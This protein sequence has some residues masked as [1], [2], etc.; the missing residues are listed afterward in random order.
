MKGL[1]AGSG[2]LMTDQTSILATSVVKHK[3]VRVPPYLTPGDTIGITCPSGFMTESDV[4]PAI[5]Q[6]E[7]WGFK[8]VV[9]KTVGKRDF[10]FGGTDEERK[11]DFQEMIDNSQIK[12][13]LC[14]RGGYGVVRMIDQ[15]D[16]SVFKQQPKWIIGFSDITVFHSHLHTNFRVATIHS[17]MCIDGGA[18]SI[19]NLTAPFEPVRRSGRATH[20]R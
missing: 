17:K 15:L 6:L 12:A 3:N 14:A 18:D 4:A 1:V 2:L 8:T 11:K 7:R 5:E 20:R 10:T 13:I 16:F 19:S 9:G